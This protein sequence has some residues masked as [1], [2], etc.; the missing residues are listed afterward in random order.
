MRRERPED[1]IQRGVIAHLHAR[2]VPNIFFFH[3]PSSRK[4]PARASAS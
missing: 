4:A 3:V 1:K 2:G